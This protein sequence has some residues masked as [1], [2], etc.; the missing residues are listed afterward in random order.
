MS[1]SVSILACAAQTDE[2]LSNQCKTTGLEELEIDEGTCC[3]LF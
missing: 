1:F 3:L 2:V